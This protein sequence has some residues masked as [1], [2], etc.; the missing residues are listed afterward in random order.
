MDFGILEMAELLNT[1]R[2]IY[3]LYAIFAFFF[4]ICKQLAGNANNIHDNITR[5]SVVS[6]ILDMEV[7]S[8]SLVLEFIDINS[9]NNLSTNIV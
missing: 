4:D 5:C 9:K 3:A 6:K 7:V 8:L 2:R 1:N